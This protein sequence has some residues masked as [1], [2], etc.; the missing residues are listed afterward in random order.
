VNIN[1]LFQSRYL[2]AADLKGQPRTVVITGVMA[3]QVGQGAEAQVKPVITLQNVKK[4]FV[5]NRT[6]AAVLADTFGDE[7]GGWIGQRIVLRSE[8]VPFQGRLVDAIRVHPVLDAAPAF[9]APVAQ[10]VPVVAAPA[11]PTAPAAP[12]QSGAFDD[13][14][15]PW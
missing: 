10:P 11:A 12:M 4:A 15:I 7:T 3:E 14:E 2:T 13:G 1:D 5:C 8:R 6:N 9:A